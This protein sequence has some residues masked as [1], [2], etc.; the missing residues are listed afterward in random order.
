ME[1]NMSE[2]YIEKVTKIDFQKFD[3]IAEDEGK[4]IK[5]IPQNKQALRVFAKILG[6]PVSRIKFS[7]PKRMDVVNCPD[8]TVSIANDNS[9]LSV[10]KIELTVP[11]YLYFTKLFKQVSPEYHW[12]SDDEYIER[13]VDVIVDA[14]LLSEPLSKPVRK[15]LME[16]LWGAR[17]RFVNGLTVDAQKCIVLCELLG[18]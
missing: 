17:E 1:N 7:Q 2:C 15:R 16:L 10:K 9:C 12:L 3:F 11:E 6:V 4:A 14:M 5:L 13:Q 18:H 8:I